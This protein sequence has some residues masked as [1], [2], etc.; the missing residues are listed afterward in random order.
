MAAGGGANALLAAIEA[1]GK[2]AEE[3]SGG[4]KPSESQVDTKKEAAMTALEGYNGV[5]FEG[6]QVGWS[7]IAGRSTPDTDEIKK[8]LGSVP[9][10]Q[11]NPSTRLSVK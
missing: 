2:K 5:T 10:K 6:I 3:E 4:A 7:E 8:A 9:M 1:R 11:G